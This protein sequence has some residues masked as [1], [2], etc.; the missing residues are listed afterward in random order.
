MAVKG[1]P[2]PVK[3]NYS[4]GVRIYSGS[5][6]GLDTDETHAR[7]LSVAADF[8]APLNKEAS[9]MGRT[10]IAGNFNGDSAYD[11]ECVDLA[12]R[13]S[14]GTARLFERTGERLL[15]RSHRAQHRPHHLEALL[16]RHDPPRPHREQREHRPEH[17]LRVRRIHEHRRLQRRRLHRSL[18]GEPARR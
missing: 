13:S 8:P 12:V 4:G 18:R 16:H 7:A 17:R 15:R 2:D 6:G 1:T 10:L 11:N 14:Y 9:Y 5:F 3:Q